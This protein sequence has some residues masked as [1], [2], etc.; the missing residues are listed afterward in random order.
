M[1]QFFKRMRTDASTNAPNG[2]IRSDVE[3]ASNLKGAT[4][5]VG[6]CVDVMR[7]APSN[8]YA[9]VLADPPYGEVVSAEWDSVGDYVEFSRE[10]LK[11]V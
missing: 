3:E 5:H 7:N 10:W 2:V 9:L 11:E 6:S 4:L 1:Q 8:R